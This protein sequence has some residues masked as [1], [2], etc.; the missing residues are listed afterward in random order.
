MR[1][2]P[3]K[4]RTRHPSGC[5]R[6]WLQAIAAGGLDGLAV[7]PTGFV[8]GQE[9]GDGCDVA[10]L[11]DAAQRSALNGFFFE[12]AADEASGL[13]TFSDNHSGIDGVDANLFRAELLS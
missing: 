7:D 2:R 13:H 5:D 12:V 9:C 4:V 10:G 8:R 6:K 11:A 3:N 1:S